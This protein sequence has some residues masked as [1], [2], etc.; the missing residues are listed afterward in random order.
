MKTNTP[1]GTCI[2]CM[3]LPRCANGYKR[4]RI[5]K[6]EKLHEEFTMWGIARYRT[7]RQACDTCMQQEESKKQN[8]RKRN[9]ADVQVSQDG[10]SA[11][12]IDM[13]PKVTIFCPKCNT[14]QSIEMNVFWK[15]VQGH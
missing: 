15:R 14:A 13:N 10:N 12:H 5:C 4:C 11:P 2:E 7:D 6:K 8:M 3:P 9:K 1:D